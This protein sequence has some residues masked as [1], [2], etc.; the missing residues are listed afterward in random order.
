MAYHQ[1]KSGK[2]IKT[3]TFQVRAKQEDQALIDGNRVY[4]FSCSDDTPDKKPG[5]LT[6]TRV[7]KSEY[8][9]A[10]FCSGGLSL[11]EGHILDIGLR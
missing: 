7:K 6:H 11:L 2:D 9:Q 1:S 3:S 10:L 8:V 4:R 5:I